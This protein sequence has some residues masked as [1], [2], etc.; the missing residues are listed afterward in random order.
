M[1]YLKRPAG[2]RT[3][4]DEGLAPALKNRLVPLGFSRE[5]ERWTAAS[6]VLLTKPGPASILE[7]R[8]GFY[9]TLLG[10]DPDP[11]PFDT[12]GREWETLA[13]GF[14]PYPCCHYNHAYLDCALDLRRTH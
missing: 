1:S 6:D 8:F 5:L 9:R 11:S 13:I 2:G 12:L 10:T 4:P 3:E 7:G 14:K